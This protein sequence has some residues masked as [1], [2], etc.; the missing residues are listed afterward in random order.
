MKQTGAHAGNT[1]LIVPKGE[2]E[3]FPGRKNGQEWKKKRDVRALK[4]TNR[5]FP[6]LGNLW[7]GSET[8]EGGNDFLL[9]VSNRGPKGPSKAVNRAKKRNVK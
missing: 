4:V 1:N 3:I 9:Q 5:H 7:K 8:R 2:R 6:F